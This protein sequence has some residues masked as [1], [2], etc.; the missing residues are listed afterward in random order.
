MAMPDELRVAPT[1][2]GTESDVLSKR[3]VEKNAEILGRLSKP[4]QIYAGRRGGVVW[5][6]DS[7]EKR[8]IREAMT[9][10]AQAVPRVR[11]APPFEILVGVGS[12]TELLEF[13]Q[14]YSEIAE[15]RLFTHGSEGGDLFIAGEEFGV[16]WDAWSRASAKGKLPR[17]TTAVRFEGCTIALGAH[18]VLRMVRSLRCPVFYAWNFYRHVSIATLKFA[19]DQEINRSIFRGW[20]EYVHI[21]YPLDDRFFT[22]ARS[23]RVPIEWFRKVYKDEETLVAESDRDIFVPRALATIRPVRSE[24]LTDN[25]DATDPS[26]PSNLELLKVVSPTDE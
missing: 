4:S 7:S 22:Q 18:N 5:V 9:L 19:K 8:H 17:V 13:L 3:A 14:N 10:I 24:D 23:F 11:Q 6:H 16:V 25:Q 12:W 1:Q 26:S 15:L 2:L 21:G 20:A